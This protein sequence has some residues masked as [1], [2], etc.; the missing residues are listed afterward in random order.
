M[1]GLFKSNKKS[2]KAKI[3][4]VDDEPDYVSTIKQ[5]LEWSN[6]ATVVATNGK[7]G[8]EKAASEKPD[9]ILLD[10]S[11]PVMDGHETLE[12]LSKD[13]QLKNIPV[14]MVTAAC[15]VDDIATASSFGIVDYISKP[16]D[17]AE[18]KDKIANALEGKKALSG[19][20]R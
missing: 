6:Y 5:H 10:T 7:E 13:P 14:I 8:L 3:L 19:V 18:L 12:H 9:L 1:F 11:M 20:G 4:I 15:E 2:G 16:F 17:F